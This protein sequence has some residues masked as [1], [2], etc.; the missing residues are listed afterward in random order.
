MRD[1]HLLGGS[2]WDGTLPAV[3]WAP[4]HPIPF[5]TSRG[6]R[7]GCGRSI[8]GGVCRC[9]GKAGWSQGPTALWGD[10]WG[11][12]TGLSP[13]HRSTDGSAAHPLPTPRRGHRRGEAPAGG[14]AEPRRG[15]CWEPAGT[16]VPTGNVAARAPCA[17]APSPAAPAEAALRPG[18]PRPRSG[19]RNPAGPVSGLGRRRQEPA[20]SSPAR[21][22]IPAAPSRHRPAAEPGG[23]GPLRGILGRGRIPLSR[24]PPLPEEGLCS[25]G[26]RRGLGMETAGGDPSLSRALYLRRD[27]CRGRTLPLPF[28]GRDRPQQTPYGRAGGAVHRCPPLPAT[29]LPGEGAARPRAPPALTQ[30]PSY[31]KPPHHQHPKRFVSGPIASPSLWFLQIT[32]FFW[33]SAP[34]GP[35]C[36]SW[37]AIGVGRV[38]RR[39]GGGTACAGRQRDRKHCP[40]V[41]SSLNNSLACAV[42][43]RR[44]SAVSGTKGRVPGGRSEEGRKK[45]KRERSPPPR[46]RTAGA[47]VHRRGRLPCTCR[48]RLTGVG[49]P[50]QPPLSCFF[51]K[52]INSGP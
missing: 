11:S 39:A 37:R 9:W 7:L 24:R 4:A 34:A 25:G 2:V 45:R 18:Q 29:A 35:E 31:G 20:P 42:S 26:A 15:Q 51:P 6:P 38:L 44:P 30:P 48:G 1:P 28:A 41:Y 32:F 33:R 40:R 10:G 46:H 23:G 49:S 12:G 14:G 27:L 17:P 19:R 3:L 13:C 21:A 50:L 5:P 36:G 47:G 52:Y 16:I 22:R 8:T 43:A